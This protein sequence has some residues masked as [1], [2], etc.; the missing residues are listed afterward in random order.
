MVQNLA[1]QGVRQEDMAI[2]LGIGKNTLARYYKD[3]LARSA[4]MAN[5]TVAGKLYAKA[6]KSG[7]NAE[8]DLDAQKFWLRCRA[9]WSEKLIIEHAGTVKTLIPDWLEKLWKDDAAAKSSD[10]RP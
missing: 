6:T 9:G 10:V 2:A 3:E 1:S 7:P 5:A 8:G 4:I